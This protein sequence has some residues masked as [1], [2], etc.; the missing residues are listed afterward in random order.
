MLLEFLSQQV[1]EN[2]FHTKEN[3]LDNTLDKLLESN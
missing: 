3:S 2:G 1:S